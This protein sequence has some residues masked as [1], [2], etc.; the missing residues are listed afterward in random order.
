MRTLPL[1]RRCSGKRFSDGGR[2]AARWLQVRSNRC[3]RNRAQIARPVLEVGLTVAIATSEESSLL[4]R[5]ATLSVS[6]SLPAKSCH[7]ELE[8]I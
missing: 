3:Y 6:L 8:V 1:N 5:I 4:M 7:L 2:G